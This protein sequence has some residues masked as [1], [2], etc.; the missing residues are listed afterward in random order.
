MP[1]IGRPRCTGMATNCAAEAGEGAGARPTS[2]EC[3]EVDGMA[4]VRFFATSSVSDRR[5]TVST[6]PRNIAHRDGCDTP[7]YNSAGIGR[8]GRRAARSGGGENRFAIF[9][10]HAIERNRSPQRSSQR[11]KLTHLV[12][13]PQL[14]VRLQIQLGSLADHIER[15]LQAPA[16]SQSCTCSSSIQARHP[17]S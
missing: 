2:S 8:W 13:D 6:L 3:A 14:A 11:Q 9:N 7:D 4:V 5:A 10:C 12:A 17:T 1:R 15:S 16:R